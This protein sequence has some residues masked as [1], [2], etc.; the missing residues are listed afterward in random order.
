MKNIYI[1]NV[2]I[3]RF[4]LTDFADTGDGELKITNAALVITV[5]GHKDTKTYN[6]GE[7]EVT[8][9]DLSC[10]SPLFDAALVSFTG[11]AVAKGI[12]AGT[13]PMGL[14]ESQFSYGNDSITV[15]F[16][17]VDGELKIDPITD[18]I[19][20][21]IKGHKDTKTYNGS[22]QKVEGYDVEISNPLY[23]ETDFRFSGN[24]VAKGTEADTYPMGLAESQF[25]NTSTN[26]T[27]VRF[28]VTDGELKITNAALVITVTGHKDTKTYNGGEQEVT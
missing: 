7:Q 17:V 24:A 22:E 19:V 23:K 15:E 10:D 18:E 20:V 26:F 27:N 13:Y 14:A 2:V 5:T 9:Y 28:V 3:F 16:N 11:E 1:C 8:G 12:N 6:G 4:C 21:T 25:T